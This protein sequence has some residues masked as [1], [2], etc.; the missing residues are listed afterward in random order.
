[1]YAERA[2]ERL[3][4]IWARHFSHLGKSWSILLRSLNS[5]TT[6]GRSQGDSTVRGRQPIR[7]KAGQQ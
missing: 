5:V 7:K 2:Q 4:G 1:M 6:G 3:E